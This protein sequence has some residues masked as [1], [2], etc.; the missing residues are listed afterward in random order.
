MKKSFVWRAGKKLVPPIL[1]EPVFNVLRLVNNLRLVRRWHTN[2]FS[3]KLVAVGEKNSYLF[4][5]RWL[6][7]DI[8]GADFDVTLTHESSLPFDHDSK[9]IIYSRHTI[10]HL[11]EQTVIAFLKESFRIL[12]PGG[13]LRVDAPDAD[14]VIDE[15]RAG[16]AEFFEPYTAWLLPERFRPTHITCIGLLSCYVE[17]DQ[18]IPVIAAKEDV[19]EK[20]RN[21]SNEEFAEWCISL[22]TAAQMKSWGHTT[23]ITVAKLK[24]WFLDIGFQ[25]IKN[26]E[27]GTSNSGFDFSYIENTPRAAYSLFV[28]GF[29]PKA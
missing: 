1:T 29:K 25:D 6:T 5:S 26:T 18:H 24:R 16:N 4:D 12:E 10:E 3:S 14:K 13:C 9:S 22:Q 19:D 21:L 23:V 28:E 7:V 2:N 11:P 15:Y 27:P 20:L 17:N 8:S